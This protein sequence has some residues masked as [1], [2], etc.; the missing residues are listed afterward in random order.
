MSS[1]FYVHTKFQMES[2]SKIK[3]KTSGYLCPT[4]NTNPVFHFLG[5]WKTFPEHKE[6]RN[7]TGGATSNLELECD[8]INQRQSYTKKK[9]D[10][11]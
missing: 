11:T 4:K 7:L 9:K 8:R 1:S 2:K 5:L 3:I 10:P 6:S